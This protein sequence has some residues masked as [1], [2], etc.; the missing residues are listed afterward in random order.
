M[1]GDKLSMSESS[2][3]SLRAP[4]PSGWQ[5]HLT[6]GPFGLVLQPTEGNV[7]NIFHRWMQRVCFGFCWKKIDGKNL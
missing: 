1:D 4:K 5:C 7:P 3:V 6:P 2:F